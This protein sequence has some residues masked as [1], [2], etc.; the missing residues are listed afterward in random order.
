MSLADTTIIII[1][2]LLIGVAVVQSKR[3]TGNKFDAGV[4]GSLRYDFTA[5]GGVAG[6]IPDPSDTQIDHFLTEQREMMEELGMDDD[7]K[8]PESINEA[9]EKSG[10][11][12]IS[13]HQRRMVGMVSQLCSGS[14]AE[15]EIMAL[16]F[17]VRQS[18]LIWIQ[19]SLLDP[20]AQA[21]GTTSERSQRTGG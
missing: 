8:D 17:R 3:Q 18:F 9:M 15:D 4:F 14:P 20:E 12:D 7:D 11:F 2:L 5:Y 16:P 6:I 19:R 21:A 10:D 13:K 1:A